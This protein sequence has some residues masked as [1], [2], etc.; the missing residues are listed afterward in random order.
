MPT[1]VAKMWDID[2][3]GGVV[4]RNAQN[5][6]PLEAL[7]ALGGFQDRE[8]A[9]KPDRVQIMIEIHGSSP[10]TDVSLCPPSC[11]RHPRDLW[12]EKA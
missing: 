1:F 5:V 4:G 12:L 7:E 6:A 2:A 11:D 9:K 3:R 10:K 8:R